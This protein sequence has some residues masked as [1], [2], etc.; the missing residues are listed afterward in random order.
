MLN[1]VKYIKFSLFYSHLFF[2]FILCLYLCWIVSICDILQIEYNLI[3]QIMK[4][5]FNPFTA[6][7]F[8]LKVKHTHDFSNQYFNEHP[9]KYNLFSLSKIV[10][11][12]SIENGAIH[13]KDKKDDITEVETPFITQFRGGFVVVHEVEP[14]KVSF[15]CKGINHDLIIAKFIEVWTVIILLVEASE[16]SN[17]LEYKEHK[18]TELLN[19]MKKATIFTDCD[20][21][22]AITYIYQ[23]FFTNSGLFF[24]LAGLFIYWLLLI[25]QMHIQSQYADII[26]LLFKQKNC[27]NLLK[28]QLFYET[29]DYD[30]VIH[31][32]NPDSKLQFTI[33]INSYY[34]AFS[35]IHKWLEE[36]LRET[37]NISVWY[38]LSSSAENLRYITTLDL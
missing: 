10:T 11:N 3:S 22:F 21:T 28:K 2:L 12:Y 8:L 26:C 15:I 30:S 1:I 25:K 19:C 27:N 34:N 5:G 6:L 35:K 29:N 4:N 13:V 20:L 18:K 33:L 36:L 16:K 32:E 24:H 37:N 23:S 14:N 9:H 7:L 31:F 17:E 38:I